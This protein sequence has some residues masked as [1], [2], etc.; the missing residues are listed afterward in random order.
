MADKIYPALIAIKRNVGAIE[1]GRKYDAAG[2]KFNYRGTDDVIDVVFPLLNEYGVI[3]AQ[4]VL[5]VVD[6][7]AG[8]SNPS[9][10]VRVRCEFKFIAE[11]GS[12]VECITVGQAQAASDKASTAA[13]SV[14]TRIALCQTLTIP[15]EMTDPEDFDNERTQRSKAANSFMKDLTTCIS[16]NALI[17]IMKQTVKGVETGTGMTRLEFGSLQD[18]VSAAAR[19]CGF[20][21]PQVKEWIDRVK[22]VA[23]GGANAQPEGATVQKP[24]ETPSVTV[25]TAEVILTAFMSSVTKAEREGAVTRACQSILNGLD[26]ALLKE[27]ADACRLIEDTSM[28]FFGAVVAARNGQEIS[29]IQDQINSAEITKQEGKIG[30][31]VANALRQFAQFRLKGLV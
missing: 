7:M 25:E 3:L 13:Q 22:L 18:E 14:A 6:A 15:F 28:F 30:K 2:T 27:V 11:D 26:V 19:K 9:P 24:T 8:K 4:R 29:G 10:V 16:G 1:K 23:A 12:Y 5:E 31:D 17:E 21:E 20:K